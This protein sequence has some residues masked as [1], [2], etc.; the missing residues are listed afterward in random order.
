PSLEVESAHEICE[1]NS[2][3]K[4]EGYKNSSHQAQLFMIETKVSLQELSHFLLLPEHSQLLFY[5]S[6]L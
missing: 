1:K 3:G 5:V 6:V 4:G 2:K